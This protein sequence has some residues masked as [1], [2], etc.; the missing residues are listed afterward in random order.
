MHL[1][2]NGEISMMI[3]VYFNNQYSIRTKNDLLYS[4]FD[5]NEQKIMK[6]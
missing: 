4:S 2:S 1:C 5:L 6:I 3:R